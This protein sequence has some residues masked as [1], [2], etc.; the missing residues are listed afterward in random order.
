MKNRGDGLCGFYPGCHPRERTD[1]VAATFEQARAE[2]EEA[3]A[4]F[5]SNRAEAAFNEWR[6]QR[7]RTARKYAMWEQ[8]EKLPSQ[9]VV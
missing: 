4:V 2:F 1:G 6:Y 3:W 9:K 7:D 8:R 5:L